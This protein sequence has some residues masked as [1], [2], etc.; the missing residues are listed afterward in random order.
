MI[1]QM[2]STK[3]NSPFETT[4]VISPKNRI[5][6]LKM[7]RLFILSNDV[8]MNITNQLFLNDKQSTYFDFQTFKNILSTRAHAVN[9]CQFHKKFEFW[10][11]KQKFYNIFCEILKN[12]ETYFSINNRKIDKITSFH[13]LCFQI[14]YF[15][16]TI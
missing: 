8:I 5:N 16:I 6:Y 14:I 4:K 2:T 10:L 9:I 13:V 15:F 3:K 11:K 7:Y 1:C 12:V